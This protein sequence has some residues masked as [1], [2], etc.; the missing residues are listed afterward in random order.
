M[1]TL[2]KLLNVIDLDCELEIYDDKDLKL[3]ISGRRSSLDLPYELY[4]VEVCQV[5]PGI[6][7]QIYVKEPRY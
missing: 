1:I 7:T 3:L 5:I 2:Y 6:V 4:D